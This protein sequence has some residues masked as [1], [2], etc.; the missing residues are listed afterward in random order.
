MRER[1]LE[2]DLEYVVFD[3]SV[4]RQHQYH[5]VHKRDWR[6]EYLD[7][8]KRSDY[9]AAHELRLKND[10]DYRERCEEEAASALPAKGSELRSLSE[11]ESER[12]ERNAA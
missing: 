11:A 8:V 7:L 2:T 4:V 3:E 12:A 1:N 9:D 10:D 6:D 5:H